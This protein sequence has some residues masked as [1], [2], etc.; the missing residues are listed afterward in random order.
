MVLEEPNLYNYWLLF[1]IMVLEEFVCESV[2]LS[3][4]GSKGKQSMIMNQGR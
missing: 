4:E 1:L 2:A 3:I